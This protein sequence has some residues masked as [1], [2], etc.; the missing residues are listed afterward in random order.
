[1]A[2]PVAQ[3]RVPHGTFGAFFRSSGRAS[4]TGYAVALAI[5]V[6]CGFIS[7][8]MQEVFGLENGFLVFLLGVAIVAVLYGTG[9]SILASF[10]STGI[11]AY[12]FMA[13]STVL[14]SPTS[15]IFSR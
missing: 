7:W 4:Y 12:Y 3:P 8:G 2:S 14:R 1:M 13:R 5:A 10:A 11:L 9:A 6:G 15:G